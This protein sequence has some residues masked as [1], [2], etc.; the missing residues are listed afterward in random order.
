[1]D[2]NAQNLLLKMIQERYKEQ[3]KTQVL[4]P[5]HY[6]KVSEINQRL[7]KLQDLFIDGE[8]ESNDYQKA[9]IRYET[10]LNELKSKEIKQT[11]QKDILNTYKNG[12][13]KL[14]SIDNL[15]INSN[16]YNKRKLIGSIFP[17]K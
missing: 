9:K 8:M 2:K 4:G 1:M 11:H 13:N 5:N 6:K 7:E 10:I 3:S 14:E 16:I 15:F 12:L 17:K